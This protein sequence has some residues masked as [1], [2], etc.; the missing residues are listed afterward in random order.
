MQLNSNGNFQLQGISLTASS[1]SLYTVETALLWVNAIF[2]YSELWKITAIFLYGSFIKLSWILEK[3]LITWPT[4]RRRIACLCTVN[5]AAVALP[6]K[7]DASQVSKA[8]EV[9]GTGFSV[10]SWRAA[11]DPPGAGSSARSNPGHG[12]IS[13]A[14]RCSYVSDT[15]LFLQENT[16][17][18]D[19]WPPA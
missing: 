13:K 4:A 1:S 8:S 5:T 15:V 11:P 14:Q 6:C 16:F 3:A 10:P 7:S 19:A 18:E 9:G 12:Y 17:Q 2:I